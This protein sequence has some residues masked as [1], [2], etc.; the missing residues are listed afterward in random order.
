[1]ASN[2]LTD[3]TRDRLGILHDHLALH[4]NAQIAES[5]EYFIWLQEISRIG[6]MSV[7]RLL[8]GD[9]RVDRHPPVRKIVSRLAPTA[10][11]SS[12]WSRAADGIC[13]PALVCLSRV[14]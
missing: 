7:W 9:R 10:V 11:V 1:M 6:G 14:S 13:Y 4:S 3:Q 8:F 2:L 5:L 12:A